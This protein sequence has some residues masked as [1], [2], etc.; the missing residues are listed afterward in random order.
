MRILL[1]TALIFGFSLIGF[2]QTSNDDVTVDFFYGTWTDSTKTGMTLTREKDILMVPERKPK[3]GTEE[4]DL[5]GVSWTYLLFL[6]KRPIVIE[7]TCRQCDDKPLP[8]K[9]RGQIEIKNER[10]IYFSSLN[11]NG[12]VQETVLLTKE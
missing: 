4:L 12:D 11:Q 9:V 6:D 8:K 2:A 1:L 7:I 5:S 3:S 10:Q